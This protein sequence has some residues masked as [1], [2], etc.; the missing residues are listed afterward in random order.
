MQPQ[1]QSY[2]IPVYKDP[3]EKRPFS[4]SRIFQFYVKTSFEILRTFEKKYEPNR[5][6][7]ID[8]DTNELQIFI[9]IISIDNNM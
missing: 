9:F 4:F 1:W 7:S 6:F 2:F 8:A 5:P 3:I